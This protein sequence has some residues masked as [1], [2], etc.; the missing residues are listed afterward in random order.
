[1]S[2]PHR[3][4]QPGCG[5]GGFT[6]QHLV[7]ELKENLNNLPTHVRTPIKTDILSQELKNYPNPHFANDLIRSYVFGFNIGYVSPSVHHIANNLKSATENLS[8]VNDCVLKELKQ[9]RVAGP[10]KHPLFQPFRTSQIGVVPKN[11][12]QFRLITDL[13]QPFGL[14][15]RFRRY[16]KKS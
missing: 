16:T 8:A 13:S 3:C 10:F 2:V 14:S 4:S 15:Q 5:G 11:N 6:K 9:K 12:G 7:Q 1:M